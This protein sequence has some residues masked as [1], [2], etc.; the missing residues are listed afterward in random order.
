MI[1]AAA[2]LFVRVGSRPMMFVRVSP[3]VDSCSRTQ[4]V[5]AVIIHLSAF[6]P[7]CPVPAPGDG[8]TIKYY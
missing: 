7:I 6:C 3:G 5:T 1:A 4:R 8:W 2:K